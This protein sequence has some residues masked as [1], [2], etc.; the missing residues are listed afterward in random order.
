MCSGGLTLRPGHVLCVCARQLCKRDRIQYPA[1][2]TEQRQPTWRARQHDLGPDPPIFEQRAG[3]PPPPSH[4]ELDVEHAYAQQLLKVVG[5]Y[6]SEAIK[7]VQGSCMR[8]AQARVKGAGLRHPRPRQTPQPPQAL[9]PRTLQLAWCSQAAS[10]LQVARERQDEGGVAHRHRAACV[11]RKLKHKPYAIAIV[12]S[13]QR[14]AL[15]GPGRK[16][17]FTACAFYERAAVKRG[18][19]SS[20]V[21]FPLLPP[22]ASGRHYNMFS[23]PI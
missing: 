21:L 2:P 19:L 20:C 9:A 8:A 15:C 12:T 7:G 22:A 14:G 16:P 1:P 17:M 13:G 10:V 3:P 18:S 4:L 11:L 23:R 6:Y 5:R